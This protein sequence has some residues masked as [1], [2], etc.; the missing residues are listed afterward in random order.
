MTVKTSIIAVAFAGTTIGGLR[1]EVREWTDASGR[2]V[3]AEFVEAADGKVKLRVAGKITLFPIEKLSAED[4]DYIKQKTSPPSDPKAAPGG[5]AP[6]ALT[7]EG[8]PLVPGKLLQVSVPLEPADKKLCDLRYGVPVTTTSVGIITPEDFDPA[9]PQKVLLVSITASS[10]K[11]SVTEIGVYQ[12]A[13]LKAGYLCLAADGEKGKG[14]GKNPGDDFG[15]RWAVMHSALAGLKRSFPGSEKW[16]YATAGFSGGGGY[17]NVLLMHLL[18]EDYTVIGSLQGGSSYTPAEPMFS[19]IKYPAAKLKKV[20]V[21]L[22]RGKTDTTCSE[23][24]FQ[25][26]I[27][28]FEKLGVKNL[29][30]EF[31]EG[32]HVRPPDDVQ[33]KAFL[34]FAEMSQK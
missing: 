12:K 19:S 20:P 25:G 34:W 26:A 11:S 13:A 3:Q 10:Q 16:H 29:R 32:G 14:G 21:M 15:L 22:V 8:Q 7:F 17:A 31:Y 4:R 5:G 30:S 6:K 18:D 27:G 9:K 33:E 2:K 23:K 28:R 24:S 1:A